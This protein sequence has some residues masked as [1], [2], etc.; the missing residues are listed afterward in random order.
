MIERIHKPWG[1][2]ENLKDDDG[3]KVKRLYIHPTQKISLQYHRQRE[4]HWVVVCGNGELELN[5]KTKNIKVG[6]YI[7]V[8]TL[9]KHR[10]TGGN[11]GIMIIEVQLGKK[12][13]EEDIVRIEDSYGRI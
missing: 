3:Y 6:D 1:W 2:Y 12:C 4:E 7:F 11:D 5:E 8:P 13:I 9:S 10:I